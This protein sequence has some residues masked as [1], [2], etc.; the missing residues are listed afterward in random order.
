MKTVAATLEIIHCPDCHGR[1]KRESKTCATCVGFGLFGWFG[2]QVVYWGRSLSRR[3]LRQAQLARLING[4]L[5]AL[6]LCASLLLGIFGALGLLDQASEAIWPIR[7]V[8][9]RGEPT[10]LVWLGA[11]GLA[12]FVARVASQGKTQRRITQRLEQF[13][14]SA[15]MSFEGIKRLPRSQWL[16]VSRPAVAAVHQ[17]VEA[18]MDLAQ[19][20]GHEEVLPLHLLAVLDDDKAIIS[21]F[22]R[23]SVLPKNIKA[24]VHRALARVP[25]HQHRGEPLISDH[26]RHVLLFAYEEAVRRRGTTIEVPDLLTAIMHTTR[27]AQAILYDAGIELEELRNVVIWQHIQRR[28]IKYFKNYQTKAANRPKGMMNRSLTAIATPFVNQFSVDLTLEAKYGRLDYCVGRDTEIESMFRAVEAGNGGLVLIGQ[29]GVGRK[30]ILAGLAQRMIMGDVP[31]FFKDKRLISLSLSSLIAGASVQGEVE[32]RLMRIIS[33]VNRSGNIIVCIDEIHNLVGVTARGNEG[34]DLSEMLA[35]YINRQALVVIGTSDPI[36]FRRAIEPGSLGEALHRIM[37]PEM[38][39]QETIRV[40]EAKT[41]QLESTQHIYFSYSSLVAVVK[42]SRRY[43]SDRFFP[44]KAVR[45]LDEVAAYVRR[46][47]GKKT[48]V[49]AEH[50]AELISDRYQVAVTEITQSE[51]EKLLHLE[52]RIHQRMVDQEEAVGMVA[53]ALRRARAELRDMKRPIAN[54]LFLGPT[55]VGKTEL[56]KTVAEVYFGSEESM[57]RFDMSE[58]QDISSISRLIGQTEGGGVEGGLLTEAIRRKP[59]TLLLLDEIEKAHPDILNLFLQVMDEGKLTDSLGRQISFSNVIIIA[60]SNAGTA[61]IQQ[62]VRESVPITAIRDELINEQLNKYF[63]PELINRF[64]GVMVFKPL[65]QEDLMKIGELMLRQVADRLREKGIELRATTDA[66]Q[67][68]VREGYDPQYGA[69][70]LRRVIQNTVD[71]ALATYLLQGKLRR[72]DVA[73]LESGKFIR[74]EKAEEL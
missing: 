18:A 4:F 55:G 52:D 1:G 53:A 28:Y 48:I 41:G 62:R 64:D 65:S 27:Q 12:W 3:D 61:L 66:L 54:F 69:R 9:E 23:L 45:L 42:H 15:E 59:Y 33:E 70:P 31:P 38:E 49:T 5:S 73:I 47:Y 25:S 10:L 24:A 37:V 20:L 46:S 50:V 72:R 63:P 21:M 39:D 60:T 7:L 68:L 17:R 40:L 57:V 51:S 22:V 74:I 8:T 13:P 34:L 29:P 6:V 44:D 71:N 11:L 19:S 2:S 14:P 35:E 16:D 67:D 36:N 26:F 58:Y 30:T 56:A 43:V 32:E